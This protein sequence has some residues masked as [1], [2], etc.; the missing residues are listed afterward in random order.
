M[1]EERFDY[2]D[3]ETLS[4]EEIKKAEKFCDNIWEHIE[5]FIEQNF[6]TF[7]ID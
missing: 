6:V 1:I 4:D 3:N 5:P 2:Q 7:D